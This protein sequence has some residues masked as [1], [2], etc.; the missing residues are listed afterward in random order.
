MP[1]TFDPVYA[2]GGVPMSPSVMEEL[3][4][5]AGVAMPGKWA[6]VFP[7][8]RACADNAID[9]ASAVGLTGGFVEE[10][11]PI[12]GYAFEALYI[13][14]TGAACLEISD[15]VWSASATVFTSAEAA[16]GILEGRNRLP[17]VRR[18]FLFNSEQDGT[19]GTD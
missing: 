2:G 1:D 14:K 4:E 10:R 5:V 13:D 3:N 11:N 12:R 8:F 17:Q 9:R 18:W 7:H 19:D 6:W 16:L 15:P